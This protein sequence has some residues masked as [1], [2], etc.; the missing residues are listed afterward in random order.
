MWWWYPE[1]LICWLVIR[2]KL[3]H[4]VNVDFNLLEMKFI[5][6]A[7]KAF[8]KV[9]KNVKRKYLFNA[10]A[11]CEYSY[12]NKLM[13][14]LCVQNV[15]YFGSLN[16]INNLYINMVESFSWNY[17]GSFQDEMFYF[18]FN[19]AKCQRDLIVVKLWF[20]KTVLESCGKSLCC[21]NQS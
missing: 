2:S 3:I 11:K 7:K 21:F 13:P 6:S 18:N 4:V 8:C 14:L 1:K 15:C 16:L 9:D 20:K 12:N 10:S 5:L 19:T 17:W